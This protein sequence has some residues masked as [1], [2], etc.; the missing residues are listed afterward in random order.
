MA[1]TGFT[2]SPGAPAAAERASRAHHDVADQASGHAT[3][4]H[5]PHGGADDVD[6]VRV[7]IAYKHML[8]YQ[9]TGTVVLAGFITVA[10]WLSYRKSSD[11][12]PL[13]VLVMLAGM[14]GALFSALTRLYNVDQARLALITP[15]VR[16]LGG[17]YMIMYSFVPP[18]IGAIAA[19]VLYLIFIGQ[20]IRG[21]MFPDIS[22]RPNMSC[23]SLSDLMAN[24]W[25]T[26]PQDYGKALVW[27]FAAG[28]SERL[29]PDL[30]QGLVSKQKAP[31]RGKAG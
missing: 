31:T 30:L 6:R 16:D 19:V 24:Y 15:T 18:V 28:F 27:A 13:L 17:R 11:P 10:L 8:T 1:V 5:E 29:V 12:L 21:G 20:L 9:F 23:A 3:G 7:L 26:N 2:E 22:C 14:I 25:P 4:G